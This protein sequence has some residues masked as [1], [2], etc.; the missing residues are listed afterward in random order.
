MPSASLPF[1]SYSDSRPPPDIAPHISERQLAVVAT[2]SSTAGPGPAGIGAF[3][4][5]CDVH[6]A[7]LRHIYDVDEPTPSAP[8]LQGGHLF[9]A[10]LSPPLCTI[11]LLLFWIV[12]EENL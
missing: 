10:F 5:P 8:K 4:A 6:R 9:P 12:D 7:L 11:I 3:E 2:V 1:P